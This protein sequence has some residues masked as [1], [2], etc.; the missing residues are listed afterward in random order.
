MANTFTTAQYKVWVRNKIDDASFDGS[1]L[2]QF[3]EDVNMEI[4]N[5]VQWP[6]MERLFVGTIGTST[7][8]FVPPTTQ[9]Q[10]INFEVTSPTAKV[11]PLTYMGYPEFVQR[12]PAPATLV[13]NAPTIYSTF[14]GNIIFGPS[15]PD[16]TY[17]ITQQY[18]ALPK[19]SLA[20][21]DVL[22]VPDDFRELVVLGM[23]ARALEHD[24]QP[25]YSTAQY[26]HFQQLL[27]LMKV[28]YGIRQTGQALVMRT[29]RSM[30]GS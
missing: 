3:A 11:L 18:I 24:D 9:Q 19:T 26:N 4:C 7:N 17:T 13:P 14:A 30:Q 15:F 28:R 5:S 21:G 12:Y 25:D 1:I 29:N 20:D 10:L 23:Y 2:T 8:T 22:D 16:Q 6:F 27:N